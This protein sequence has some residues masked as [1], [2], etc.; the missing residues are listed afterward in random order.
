MLLVDCLTDNANQA[1]G[2]VRPAFTKGK[3]K[4]VHPGP[5]RTCSSTQR[6]SSSKGMKRPCL[7]ASYGRR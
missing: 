3:G 7:S 1:I 2:E 6:C 4:M 5:L